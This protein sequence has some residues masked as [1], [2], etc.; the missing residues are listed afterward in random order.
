MRCGWMA[1]VSMSAI[2]RIVIVPRN[3]LL[4]RLWRVKPRQRM[5]DLGLG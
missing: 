1:D 5:I 2:P 4:G 3:Y